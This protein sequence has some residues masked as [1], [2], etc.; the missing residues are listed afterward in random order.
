MSPPPDFPQ[1]ARLDIPGR[2]DNALSVSELNERIRNL[3]EDAFPYVRVRG[4]VSGLRKPPSGHVYFTLVDAESQIRCVVWRTTVRRLPALPRDGEAILVTGRVAVYAP[5]GEYQLVVEGVVPQ[6]TGGERER[7]LQLH[8]K[9][10]AEGLFAETRKRPLP[11]L[12]EIIGVVTSATGAVIHDIIQVL[13]QRFP[14][15]HLLLAHAQVQGTT[16]PAEIAAALDLLNADGRAQVIVCGRGGGS[17]EDLAAFNTETVVRAIARS[18]IPVVSAVGH[19]VD[20]TLADLVADLRC[21]TPSAAAERLLPEKTILVQ[22]LRT[23]RDRLLHA[24]RNHV[25]HLRERVKLCRTRVRDPRRHLE[26]SR[27]RCDDLS[28][29]LH[30]ILRDTLS[31]QQERLIHLQTRLL[32][33]KE[34]HYLPYWHQKVATLLLR[35]L[36]IARTDIKHKH[37]RLQT[38]RLRLMAL[39]PQATLD[40][41]FAIVRDGQGRT[42]RQAKGLQPGDMLDV[43]LAEGGVLARVNRLKE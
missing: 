29:R 12:P 8:A 14:G 41:G 39:S 5:R 9:L 10:T 24:A 22:Q 7:L 2:P 31:G 42:L 13:D 28:E 30:R 3:L 37:E 6:G 20:V 27:Q 36:Q 15:Y 33:W 1:P 38:Q 11:F 4:E 40:R 43:T 18:K 19:E 25:T 32:A 17:A 21:P 35:L 23:L 16:A 26:Q 34:G